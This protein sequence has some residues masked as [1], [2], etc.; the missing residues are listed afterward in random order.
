MSAQYWVLV[1]LSPPIPTDPARG[2]FVKIENISF[3]VSA[4]RRAGLRF[5]VGPV[6]R[7]LPLLLIC[8]VV[9][10]SAAA[11]STGCP[12]NSPGG[13]ISHVVFI[14]F[15]N[16]H[17]ERDVPNVPADLEQMPNLLNFLKNNGTFFANH[18]TPL[19]SHT[20]DD[21]L[22][23]LTGVYPDQHGQA[24]A[25]SF[26][27]WNQLADYQSNMSFWDSFPS[28]FTYWTD[29][30]STFP[31]SDTQYSMITPEGLNAPAP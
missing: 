28:S 18:H 23:S 25:N 9:C 30:V 1:R 26:V 20:A 19:I 15:D 27:V 10:G 2:V 6:R 17:F 21:I 29:P 31:T 16:V 24:V 13:Q 4:Q 14:Q 11:Q 3:A 12:L 8:A 22:T 7:M 5:A